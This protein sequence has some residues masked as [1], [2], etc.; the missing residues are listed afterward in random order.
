MEA[1]D[2]EQVIEAHLHLAQILQYPSAALCHLKDQ[3]GHGSSFFS[4]NIF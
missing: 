1:L 3:G 4:L 2:S